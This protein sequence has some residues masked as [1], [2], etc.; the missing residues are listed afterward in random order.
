MFSPNTSVSLV[1]QVDNGEDE[2]P[3]HLQ[4]LEQILSASF[5]KELLALQITPTERERER[6]RESIQQKM[7]LHNREM[8]FL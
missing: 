7:K 5:I 4:S 3:C 1:V 8:L 6:E 2:E